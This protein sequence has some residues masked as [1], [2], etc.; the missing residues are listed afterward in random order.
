MEENNVFFSTNVGNFNNCY[1][2]GQLH[3][4]ENRNGAHRLNTKLSFNP[5]LLNPEA[6]LDTCNN[7]ISIFEEKMQEISHTL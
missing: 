4:L 3:M 7:I 1:K 5:I 2:K 6:I